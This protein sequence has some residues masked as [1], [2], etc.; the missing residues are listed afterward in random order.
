MNQKKIVLIFAI[1]SLLIIGILPIANYI[2]N[3]KNTTIE[4]M[5]NTDIFESYRNYFF[6]KILNRSLINYNVIVGQDDF[7]FLGNKHNY[8][9]SKTQNIYP[10]NPKGIEN[11]VNNLARLQQWYEDKGIKFIMAIVPNKHTIYSDK[12]PDWVSIKKQNVTDEII[13][14][15]NSKSLN[16]LDLR[17]S[18]LASKQTSNELLY[19]KTD[20]H[21]NALGASIGYSEIINYLNDR[22]QQ[23]YQVPEYTFVLRN[24]GGKGLSRLLK[25][26]DLIPSDFERQV[27]YRFNVNQEICQGGIEKETNEL[28]AC[29]MSNSTAFNIHK[30]SQYSINQHALNSDSVLFLC[31]SFSMQNSRLF[32]ATFNTIWKF[33]YNLFLG[34]DLSN[35]VEKQQPQIVIYQIVERSLYNNYFINK[36]LND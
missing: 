16:L 6:F 10:N 23:K 34:D 22:Y 24:T 11:W 25:S 17:K 18:L 13:K 32:N 15:S 21:W 28:E 3:P 19:L 33:H 20:S 27:L 26:S 4:N 29:Q 36:K 8:V 9:I 31:D 35:F 1:L 7:L 12:L 14:L 5:F 30:G 2:K